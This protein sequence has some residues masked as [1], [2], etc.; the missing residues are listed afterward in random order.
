MEDSIQ[1]H[2]SS[3]PMYNIPNKEP[4]GRMFGIEFGSCSYEDRKQPYYGKEEDWDVWN[5]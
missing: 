1:V 4:C 5:P 3:P 2:G